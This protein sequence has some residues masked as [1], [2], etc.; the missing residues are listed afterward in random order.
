[1]PDNLKEYAV[2]VYASSKIRR[3]QVDMIIEELGGTVEVARIVQVVP[4]AV[5]NWRRFG[6]FPA[7]TY[8][9]LAGR[10]LRAPTPAYLWGMSKGGKRKA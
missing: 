9:L 4:S 7:Y 8:V 10:D 6:R 1:V 2:P 5:S 3:A